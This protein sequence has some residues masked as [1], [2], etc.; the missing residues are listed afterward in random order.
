MYHTGCNFVCAYM[1]LQITFS[2]SLLMSVILRFES[3]YEIL[4]CDHCIA[5]WKWAV[6]HSLEIDNSALFIFIFIFFCLY[7]GALTLWAFF[8]TNTHQLLAAHNIH[9]NLCNA[10]R[11]FC[12]FSVHNEEASWKGL[13]A[14]L[15]GNWR[16]IKV[17][18]RSCC[19]LRM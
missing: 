13:K 15:I 9:K 16:E 12:P 2:I 17:W 1:Y 14:C 4:N 3:V 7:L 18:G 11:S 5:S 8:N 6:Y 10:H 19:L